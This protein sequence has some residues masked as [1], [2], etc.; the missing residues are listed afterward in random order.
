MHIKYSF[1]DC[2]PM[3]VIDIYMD[4]TSYLNFIQAFKRE[5]KYDHSFL[6]IILNKVSVGFN[7]KQR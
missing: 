3:T 5:N 6:N 7:K 4:V 1:S 2:N